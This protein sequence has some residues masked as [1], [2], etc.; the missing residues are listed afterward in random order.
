M[1]PGQHSLLGY[2]VD[3]ELTG[4]H[5]AEFTHPDDL[6]AGLAKM[7]ELSEG[8]I[9]DVPFTV[10]ARRADGS[11]VALELTMFDARADPVLGGVVMRARLVPDQPRD[12]CRPLLGLEPLAE[13]ISSG[14]LAA[15]PGGVVVYA[16]RAAADLLGRPAHDLVHHHWRLLV[17]PADLDEVLSAADAAM[18]GPGNHEVVFRMVLDGDRTRWMHARINALGP[19]DDPAGWVAVV[20]DVTR[21]RATEADL[22]HR[23]THDPLTGLPNR[24]LLHDRLEQAIARLT[25]AD[26]HVAV[27]FL[28]IDKFKSINDEFGHSVGDA[29]LLDLA[30]RI[31]HAIRPGDTA[32]RVGGDEFVIIADD[33]DEA[34]AV[35]IAERVAA[36]VQVRVPTSTTPIEIS[37]S[38]GIALAGPG[39]TVDDVLS[40][41]D[42]AMYRAKRNPESSIVV[43]GSPDLKVVCS[44][45]Y[46]TATG[47]TGALVAPVMGSGAA[48]RSMSY[49]PSA[50]QSAARASR[51][52]FW[53]WMRPMSRRWSM[54][55]ASVSLQSGEAGGKTS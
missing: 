42:Q 50:A 20:Q 26:V 15:E 12:R 29:T 33:V 51:F 16:N 36:A 49:W 41:A 55:T 53:P 19:Q 40:L 35:A 5:L 46:F 9:P 52:Q 43:A 18:A 30:T 13:A 47:L 24:L 21:Q 22:A 44:A 17:H 4:R 31:Q 28:D 10:R 34:R 2:P 7:V 1:L 6:A 27:M 54:W 25:R 11:W 37:T 45:S 14:V 8:E 38:I 39:E 23:A 3:D 32:A 48:T